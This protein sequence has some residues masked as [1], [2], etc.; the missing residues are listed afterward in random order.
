MN[1]KNHHI[2]ISFFFHSDYMTRVENAEKKMRFNYQTFASLSTQNQQQH[3]SYQ[4]EYEES[5]FC[6]ATTNGATGGFWNVWKSVIGDKTDE[7]DSK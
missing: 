6:W 7:T 3:R 2:F 5:F 1:E 4:T